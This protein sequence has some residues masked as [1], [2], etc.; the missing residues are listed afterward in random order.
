MFDSFK[1]RFLPRNRHASSWRM[2]RLLFGDDQ[3]TV[4][5]ALIR[6]AAVA[7]RERIE[8]APLVENLGK[9]HRGASRGR[10][11]R[12]ARRMKAGSTFIEAL[13]QTPDLLRD[14]DLLSLKFA[15]QSGTL[16]QAYDE[17]ITR[18]DAR[19]REPRE[20]VRRALAY[21]I[22]LSIAFFLII[23]FQMIFIAPTFK[24]MFEEFGLRLPSPLT[25]LIGVTDFLGQFLPLLMLLGA[26]VLALCWLL[27]PIRALHRRLG[28]RIFPSVAQLRRSQ[29]LRML[30]LSS[31]AGR[32]LPGSLS[33]LARYHFDPGV[34]LKLLVARNEVEQGTDAWRSLHDASLLSDS[35]ANA[36]ANAS[37]PELRSW[38]M[39]RLAQQREESI[40]R[41]NTMLSL[42]L[43]PAIVLIF[44]AI[45]LWVTLAFFSVLILMISSLS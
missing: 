25:G 40:V 13:E 4:S 19:S 9:E 2:T 6:L 22:G 45:T 41:K 32:P 38:T 35:E 12:L 10:L 33:T 37:S 29:L 17:M 8:L 24:E 1:D 7:G 26:V 20:H 42:L 44:G 14:E 11:L 30:A 34:R 43:H 16:P 27:K 39:R 15:S 21:A 3:R 36:F 23:A 18:F 5:Q 28:S 31:D